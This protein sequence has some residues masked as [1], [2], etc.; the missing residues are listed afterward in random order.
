VS[1]YSKRNL[2]DLTLTLTVKAAADLF[3]VGS[4]EKLASLKK[5]QNQVRLKAYGDRARVLYFG[6]SAPDVDFKLIP[7][8]PVKVEPAKPKQAKTGGAPLKIAETKS[9]VTVANAFYGVEFNRATGVITRITWGDG[10]R[11]TRRP[12]FNESTILVKNDYLLGKLST[13]RANFELVREGTTSATV[14]ITSDV[15]TTNKP[16]AKPVT[17]VI[18]YTFTSESPLIRASFNV[19]TEDVYANCRINDFSFSG[20][21]WTRIV[22]GPSLR[23]ETMDGEI[24]NRTVKVKTRTKGYSYVG[25]ADDAGNVLALVSSGN[26]PPGFLHIYTI[27]KFYLRGL[28]QRLN[29]ETL[30]FSQRLYI[31]PADQMDTWIQE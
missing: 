21:D 3:D 11:S 30:A 24:K 2:P 16:N 10:K 31:G 28:Y 5:G 6:K 20:E 8:A 14:R 17:A 4:G 23:L 29:A 19:S 25:V 27:D 13:G 1:D 22:T 15:G 7:S 9:S 26:E 12:S 18:E